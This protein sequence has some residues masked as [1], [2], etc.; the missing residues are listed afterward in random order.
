MMTSR[1]TGPRRE[2][3]GSAK[4]ALAGEL[5]VTTDVVVAIH[6][7]YAKPGVWDVE[8]TNGPTATIGRGQI[9]DGQHA[10]SLRCGREPSATQAP[11]HGSFVGRYDQLASWRV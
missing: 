3:A 5:A 1:P 2:H 8:W 6:Y 4:R 7:V 10:R 11:A 9:V